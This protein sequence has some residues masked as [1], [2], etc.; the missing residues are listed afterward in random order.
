MQTSPDLPLFE[1]AVLAGG[2]YLGL[3]RV[4]N[5]RTGQGCPKCETVQAIVAFGLAAWAGWEIW[6]HYGSK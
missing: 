6:T 2:L 4:K 3:G 5:L 1:L